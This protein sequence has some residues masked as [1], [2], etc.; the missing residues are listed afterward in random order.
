MYTLLKY[1]EQFKPIVERVEQQIEP[2]IREINAMSDFNQ[3]K[4][5]RA[6]QEEEVSDYHFS[7][8]TAREP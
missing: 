3:F 7:P 2:R 6:F 4:V 5:L 8:S 1:G